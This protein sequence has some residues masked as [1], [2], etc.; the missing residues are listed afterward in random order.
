MTIE[1]SETEVIVTLD[2]NPETSLK[3][4]NHGATV[5]SWKVNGKEQLWLSE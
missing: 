5:V 3:I 1:Q 2:S 4:I